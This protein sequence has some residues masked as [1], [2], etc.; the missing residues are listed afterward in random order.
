MS[1]FKNIIF[2]RYYY[3]KTRENSRY[4]ITSILLQISH[5][6][7]GSKLMMSLLIQ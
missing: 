3:P 1:R 2:T 7:Y 4:I 6:S 5:N